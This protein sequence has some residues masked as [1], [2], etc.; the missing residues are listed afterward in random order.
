[1]GGIPRTQARTAQAVKHAYDMRPPP[2]P[3]TH[4]RPP[5]GQVI[6]AITASGRPLVG[7]NPSLDLAHTL[8][9][10]VGPLPPAWP[11]YKEQLRATFPGGLYD[12][13]HLAGVVKG[14]TVPET[15]LPALY[16]TLHDPA[17]LRQVSSSKSYP[18]WNR[19]RGGPCQELRAW[20]HHQDLKAGWGAREGRGWVGGGGFRA[21]LRQVRK[22][23]K[24]GAGA[25]GGQGEAGL[26]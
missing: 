1:M 9:Q 20:L 23:P 4:T 17:W 24:A 6:E 10:F 21:W 25:R 3:A 15:S 8:A 7:H 5:A 26:A 13:K 16:R 2:L 14:L 18:D 12:T 11:A 19:R 22:V